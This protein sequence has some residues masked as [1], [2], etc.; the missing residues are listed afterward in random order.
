MMK[1]VLLLELVRAMHR[2]D[3]GFLY[4][5]THAG[6][7]EYDLETAAAG[8]SLARQPEWPD[9]IGRLWEAR[10]L[11]PAVAGYLDLVRDHDRR[12]GNLAS[13]PRF[14]PGSPALVAAR[15][16]PVDRI[17]L[18]E[19]H[20]AECAALRGAFGWVPR[21]EVREGDGYGAVRALLPPRE[22]RALV[23]LDPPYE[24]ADEFARVVETLREGLRRFPTGVVAAWYPLTGRARV[25]EFLAAVRQLAPPPALAVELA[26]AREEARPK[27]SGC[28][29]LVL[30]PPWQF[31]ASA[32]EIGSFLASILAQAPGGGSRVEWIVAPT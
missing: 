18:C 10:E 1:H 21:S 14:Y 8:D 22:R 4:L 26:V 16:R 24:A 29:L 11:P 30:N 20:P 28:G 31:D 17:V 19:K 23:L 15:T 25:D 27:L 3:R 9:G 6:R 5:D 2:K 12:R 13:T 7:G 32:R